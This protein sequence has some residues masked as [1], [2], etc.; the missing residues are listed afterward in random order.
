MRALSPPFRWFL[1]GERFPEQFPP[2]SSLNAGRATN[3]T[4]VTTKSAFALSRRHLL[5]GAVAALTFAPAA[6]AQSGPL[7]R[8]ESSSGVSSFTEESF[9]ALPQSVLR[10]HTA[11]TEGPREFQGVALKDLLAAAGFD[12]AALQGRSLRLRALNEYEVAIPAEDCEIYNPLLARS[13]DGS[14]MLRSDKGPLWLVYPRDQFPE[15]HDQRYDHRWAWQL[16]VIT[17]V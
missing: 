2:P 12:S 10:T 3:E 9:A 8:V 14:P 13:M 1:K 11:W 15:L 17:V 4:A 16:A 5:T 7:L 6:R